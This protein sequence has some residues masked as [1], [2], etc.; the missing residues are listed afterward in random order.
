MPFFAQRK[1][2]G[3]H[4]GRLPCLSIAGAWSRPG[5]TSGYSA[6]S[7]DRARGSHSQQPPRPA[8]PCRSVRAHGCSS[9]S[10]RKSRLP[11][12][13]QRIDRLTQDRDRSPCPYT[14]GASEETSRPCNRLPTDRQ[15]MK[16]C[17]RLQVAIPPPP[18]TI[19]DGVEEFRGCYRLPYYFHGCNMER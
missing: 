1:A 19:G 3:K 7:V 6:V 4:H 16:S 11:T 9:P 14:P 17:V 12:L 5:A 15:S 2:R 10:T 13:S 18:Y 8:R